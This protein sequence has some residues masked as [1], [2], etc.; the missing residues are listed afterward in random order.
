[1]S[2]IYTKKQTG[3]GM[4]WLSPMCGWNSL[5]TVFVNKTLSFISDKKEAE[6]KMDEPVHAVCGKKKNIPIKKYYIYIQ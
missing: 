4:N 6:G 2:L 3:G 1:M 5:K